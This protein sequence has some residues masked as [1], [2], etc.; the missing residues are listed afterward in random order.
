[1]LGVGFGFD[2]R[3]GLASA[4]VWAAVAGL[5]RISS[6]GGMASAVAAPVVAWALYALTPAS[7][8]N[9]GSLVGLGVFAVV[10]A[11]MALQVLWKH[12]ANIARLLAGTEPRI[13]QKG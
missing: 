10:L 13:G 8:A 1:M 4:L 2:W 12:R 7:I 5:T 6:A 11:V 3:I 9:V